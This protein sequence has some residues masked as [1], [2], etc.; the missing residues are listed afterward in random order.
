MA[1]G[2]VQVLDVKSEKS[3]AVLSGGPQV[4]QQLAFSLD[5]SRLAAGGWDGNVTVWDIRSQ[6]AL[7][8]FRDGDRVMCLAFHPN[9][10]QLAYG[11]WDN[12]VNICDLETGREI[13]TLRGHI[14]CVTSV[15]YSSDGQ[16]LATTS[17][18]RYQG[19]VQ[20]WDTARFGRKR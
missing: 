8:S 7:Y 10:R 9:G 5:G 4:P 18:N 19:E 11:G 3:V 6:K 2:N 14:G 17:G 1:T 12:A 20:L 15:T 13:E 16:L